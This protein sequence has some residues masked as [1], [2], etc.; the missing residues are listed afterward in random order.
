MIKTFLKL[1][2]IFVIS[3]FIPSLMLIL[4]PIDKSK[5]FYTYLSYLWG[6]SILSVC[7]IK[8]SAKNLENVLNLKQCVIVANHASMFDIIALLKVLPQIRFMYKKELAPVPIWG[9]AL[10]IG[11]H[12][13]INRK[14]GID[15][16]RSLDNAVESLNKGGY[17]ILFAEGTRTLD[18]NLLPFKRGA[19]LLAAKSGAPIIP[20]SINGTFGIKPKN[21]WMINSANVELIFHDAIASNPNAT[22]EEEI[23]LLN[24][25]HE[26]ISKDYKGILI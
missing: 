8:V 26:I 22:R 9:W 7:G 10:Q 19:F 11:P 3:I 12:I 15:A 17:V 5:K 1:F 18:G 25:T 21:S 14:K 24:K 16:M 4:W 23:A 6:A 20:L 2:S 13:K